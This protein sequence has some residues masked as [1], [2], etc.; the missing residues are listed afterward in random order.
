MAVGFVTLPADSTGKKERTYDY[1]AEGHLAYVIPNPAR[2]AP[3]RFSAGTWAI[4]TVALAATQNLATIANATGST[5][6][7]ALRSVIVTAMRT[8]TTAVL[9]TSPI[10]LWA[11][12]TTVPSGG[13]AMTK[14]KLDSASAASA[15]QVSVLGASSVDN[16]ASAITYALPTAN[17]FAGTF[18]PP[19]LTGTGQFLADP[20]RLAL[21]T[22]PDPPLTLRAG[23]S[24]L[25][26]IQANPNSAAVI[27]AVEFVWEEFTL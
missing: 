3:V 20:Y 22:E 8:S 1:G 4:A 11:P 25:V 17:P 27:L 14:H 21:L 23:D 9:T 6:L 5:V 19:T 10:R 16:T 26:T 13:T 18:F 12:Q 24:C 7:V 2:I 15:T